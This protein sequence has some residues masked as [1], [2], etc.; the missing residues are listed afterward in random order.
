MGCQA[1]SN[2]LVAWGKA[3][4]KNAAHADCEVEANGSLVRSPSWGRVQ[5]P[6]SRGR[7]PRVIGKYERRPVRQHMRSSAFAVQ[8]MVGAILFDRMTLLEDR[9]DGGRNRVFFLLFFVCC[10]FDVLNCPH[11]HAVC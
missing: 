3:R 9:A 6:P 5:G 7:L 2:L 1:K 10:R 11:R 8:V 4:E